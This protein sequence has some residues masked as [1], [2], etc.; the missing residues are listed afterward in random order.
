[1]LLTDTH[2]AIKRLTAGKLFSPKQAE[3]IVELFSDAD[4]QVATKSDIKLLEATLGNRLSNIQDK[5]AD[6][7]DTKT[8]YAGLLAQTF[9]I[10]SIL[11]ALRFF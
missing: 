2:S 7:V 6:K 1:M 11:A 3:K 4:E 8:Y 5:I 10:L 9:A